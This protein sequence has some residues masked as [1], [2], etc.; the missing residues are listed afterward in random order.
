MITVLMRQLMESSKQGNQISPLY[1]NAAAYY[2]S[3]AYQLTD[4]ITAQTDSY[5][6]FKEAQQEARE[7]K[8]TPEEDV[9]ENPVMESLNSFKEIAQDFWGGM[10][11]R[12]EKKFDSIY[13]FGNYVTIGALDAGK[14]MWKGMEDRADVAL[15]SPSNFINY[16]TMGGVD[17]FNGA[18]NPDDPFS[19]EHWM[20]SFSLGLLAVGGA[21]PGLKVKG[22]TAV[23]ATARQAL[24]KVSLN[25]RW[26]EIRLGLDDL[27]NRPMMATENGMLKGGFGEPGFSKFSVE[28]EVKGEVSGIKENFANSNKL[29]VKKV[30][31]EADR[32]KLSS[33]KYPPDDELYLKYKD[34]FD[35]SK[36]YNQETGD[37]NWPPNNGFDGDPKVRVLEEGELIDRYGAPS[38]TF[39]SP[40]GVEFD[41]RALALHSEN[42]PYHIYK[43]LEPFKV[44]A[45]KIAPWFDKP[46]GGTQFFTGNIKV[47]DPDTGKMVE[48]TVRNLERLGYIR[49]ISQ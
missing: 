14:D 45:G 47:L 29:D 42:S 43:V 5:L 28:R 26:K 27:Y 9:N 11:N 30:I 44:E 32:T 36:Y 38:G 23:S 18:V 25:Q 17:L 21:K 39:L 31:S 6:K 2:S 1:F 34:T 46:G 19:K 37:I 24:P 15:D 48:A 41:N 12:N 16:L 10:E 33:W 8:P 49:D 4:D 40:A 7:P 22:Q 35:N 13:D 20:N 3:D